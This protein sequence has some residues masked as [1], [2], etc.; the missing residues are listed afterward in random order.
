MFRFPRPLPAIAA[1]TLL[2][3]LAACTGGTSTSTAPGPFPA[4]NP[5]GTLHAQYVVV[6]DVGN[7]SLLT[8]NLGTGSTI[9]AGNLAPAYNNHSATLV[10]PFFIFNDFNSNLWAANFSGASLTWYSV[11]GNGATPVAHT[12][13]GSNTT[14]GQPTGIYIAANGTIYV[15]DRSSSH[16][17]ATIDEFAPGS[18]GNVAPVAWIGGATS[19]LTNTQGLSMDSRGN[20]WVINFG[21]SQV[22]EFSSSLSAGQNNIAPTAAMTSAVFG[23][24]LEI[25]I[26]GQSHLW[27]G[28]ASDAATGKP[29]L[30]EFNMGTGAQ[31]PICT[32]SGANTGLIAGDQTTVA[33]DNG[34]YVYAVDGDAQ[35]SIFAKG[36][37]GNVAP[38]YTISGASTGLSRPAAIVVYSTGNDY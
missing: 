13:S 11:T 6:G 33:V 12:I 23:S 27:F 24:P 17:Y 21:A 10:T 3:A 34:G 8:Y 32:I 28:D 9:T 20:L 26:D 16:G 29:A 25:Y 2:I 38:A 19:T 30:F 22:D 35:V 36:Q 18:S 15:S 5:G 1:V 4:V 7:N 14:L 37:C 31:V